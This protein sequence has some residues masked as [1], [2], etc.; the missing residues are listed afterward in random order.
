[1][2]VF[3]T[4]LYHLYFV[5]QATTFW[6]GETSPPARYMVTYL[7]GI[8]L[9]LMMLVSCFVST[10]TL[11]KDSHSRIEEVLLT[12]AFGNLNH[13]LSATLAS[14]LLCALPI[15][16]FTIGVY[17]VSATQG[18]FNAD[19]AEPFE[20]VSVSVFLIFTTIVSL[21]FVS[22]V[23]YYVYSTVRVAILG[24]LASMVIVIL[25]IYLLTRVSFN[26]FVFF[27]FLPLVGDVAS[28]M[29]GNKLDMFDYLRFLGYISLC[30][31]L[32][33]GAT[34]LKSRSDAQGKLRILLF[35]HIGAIA[36]VSFSILLVSWFNHSSNVETWRRHVIAVEDD[37]TLD[38]KNVSG[39]VVLR[40]GKN[41]EAE[42]TISGTSVGNVSPEDELVF[43]LNPGFKVYLVQVDSSDI[44]FVRDGGTLRVR[45]NR[46]ITSGESLELN[47]Q[48]RGKPNT[49]YGY[50]NSALD[51]P[52]TPFW[53]QL[54]SYYGMN[55]SVF[56]R[57]YVALPHATHWLPTSTVQAKMGFGSVDFVE[58]DLSITTPKNWMTTLT[59]SVTKQQLS[60]TD[61]G[62]HTLQFTSQL[63]SAGI[64]LY[65]SDLT[66]Y[67]TYLEPIELMLE[68]YASDRHLR[69]FQTNEDYE[70]YVPVFKSWLIEK[71]E[72]AKTLGY[73]FP[74]ESFRLVVVPSN[75]RLYGGGAFMDSTITEPC[76][77]LI[78]EHGAVATKPG[79]VLKF[80]GEDFDYTPMYR[81]QLEAYFDT[82]HN[83]EN[84]ALSLPNHYLEFQTG[85]VGLEGPFLKTVLSYLHDH[86]WSRVPPN[87]SAYTPS[88]FFPGAMQ[89]KRMSPRA[90]FLAETHRMPMDEA[91]LQTILKS[92]VTLR[93]SLTNYVKR[94]TR[95]IDQ[96]DVVFKHFLES[97]AVVNIAVQTSLQ[98]L[99]NLE[100]TALRHEA[101]RLRCMALAEK[102]YSFLGRANSRLLIQELSNKFQYQNISE[103]AVFDAADS[104][105]LP[106][107]EIMAG[108]Y[109]ETEEFQF[110][111]SAATYS[112]HLNRD[113]QEPFY[114]VVFDIANTGSTAGVFRALVR[115]AQE[116]TESDSSFGPEEDRELWL[117]N[118]NSAGYDWGP[119]I[120]V[121]AGTTKQVGIV[122]S[123]R[124]YRVNLKSAD[125]SY[126][127]EVNLLVRY[128]TSA[129]DETEQVPFE[130]TRTSTWIPDP[131]HGI[132]LDDI[133]LPVQP[134][135]DG[136]IRYDQNLERFDFGGAWG[137]S[138]K[139]F[140]YTENLKKAKVN[141]E[142]E[143]PTR[144][145]WRIE[146]H[147]PDI[148]GAQTVGHRQRRMMVSGRTY[149][150]GKFEGKY[151]MTISNG[152]QKESLEFE[153]FNRDSGWLSIGVAE[154]AAGSIS[155][156]ISPKL[157]TAQLFFDA[158]RF[159]LP[160]EESSL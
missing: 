46:A 145:D 28:D 59:G 69:S 8:P 94:Y 30:T 102:I 49:Q 56:D 29:I 67:T 109:D 135:D 108:W 159:V 6:E 11:A 90:E 130:G 76:T 88:A 103:A 100:P 121:P 23:C 126:V 93:K 50:Q 98:T 131:I 9:V 110:N 39:G 115:V 148:R 146:F 91:T 74:C 129:T 139:S 17:V 63:P 60:T 117:A 89:V 160:N 125:V 10:R 132:V 138:R 5:D 15:I 107:R 7:G 141:V 1:M 3:S 20:L 13:A 150:K 104:L 62:I 65:A 64:S 70:K 111:F 34:W 79:P 142:A 127:N 32:A 143:L 97:D 119:R 87:P 52:N 154:L 122:T 84:L 53:D 55:A 151:E 73:S 120:L 36:C 33:V 128:D 35:G 40:P 48:Y 21:N 71:I 4:I 116:S 75:L 41:M 43:W 12:K 101:I 149:F 54:I 147:V 57:K 92:E 86:T 106:V 80:R 124:P 25:I 95:H 18:W 158:M 16:G 134:A 112:K 113:T 114:Q 19:V 37:V 38:I 24:V 44:P 26:Q 118:L 68:L 83:G 66:K 157:G 156:A 72:E 22:L 155:V 85:I 133:D 45:L 140:V 123:K 152:N 31:M 99:A 96:T 61:D 58:A 153:V 78:R 2:I 81:N 137:T 51:V 42:I 82:R 77:Y 14:T 105:E 136:V 27:E 47:I 144:E